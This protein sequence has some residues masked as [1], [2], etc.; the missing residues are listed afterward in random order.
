MTLRHAVQ[1]GIRDYQQLG[2]PKIKRLVTVT[3][4]LPQMKLVTTNNAMLT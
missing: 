2:L 3:E 4:K 1:C